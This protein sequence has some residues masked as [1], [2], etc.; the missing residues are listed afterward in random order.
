MLFFF[1]GSGA[2]VGSKIGKYYTIDWDMTQFTISILSWTL[3]SASNDLLCISFVH[4]LLLR[5]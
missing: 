5:F 3:G 2:S 1:L 4:C